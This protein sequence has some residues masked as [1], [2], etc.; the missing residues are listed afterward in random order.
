LARHYH[1]FRAGPRSASF[2]RAAQGARHPALSSLEIAYCCA[3][4]VASYAV[5]GSTGF[6]SAAAMPLLALAIPLKI[7]VVSG[8]ALVAK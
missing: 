6:G 8:A 5:R 3:A 7:L 4:I 2:G 1:V